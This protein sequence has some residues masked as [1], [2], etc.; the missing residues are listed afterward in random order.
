MDNSDSNCVHSIFR[1]TEV[2]AFS[3]SAVCLIVHC[4]TPL[5]DTTY[6]NANPSTSGSTLKQLERAN[7][8]TCLPD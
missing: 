7:E 2:M 5:S 3:S 6:V 8:F 4:N 1:S